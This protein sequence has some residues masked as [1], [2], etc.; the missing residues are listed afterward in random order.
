MRRLILLTIA[1]VLPLSGCNCHDEFES[2]WD[3]QSD[4]EFPEDA[5]V[6]VT[7]D[8]EPD[9]ADAWD[10]PP[11]LV[12]T[13]DVAD[14]PDA[15]PVEPWQPEVVESV[16]RTH[17]LTDRT[18]LAVDPDG[19][20]WLGYHEC[21][22]LGCD[23]PTLK[24]VHKPVGGEWAGERIRAHEGI[25]GVSVI[26]PQKPIVVFPDTLED[27]YKAAMRQ[28]DGSWRFHTFPVDRSRTP[29]YDGF[30]VT[31]DG[32]SYFVSF[33]P[34]DAQRVEF[35]AYDTTASRPQWRRKAPL[36]VTNPQAAMERGL[37]ADNGDSVY[38]VNQSG[39]SGVYGVYRYDE[40]V[41]AWPQSV[42]LEQLTSTFVH[43][44]F[45]TADYRLCMSGNY[46]DDLL[47]T[48]GSMFDLTGE[49]RLFRG[50]RLAYGHPSSIIE[51]TDGTLY[52]AFNPDG[53]DELRVARRDVVTGTWTVETVFDGPSYG[54]S[55]A[56]AQSGD[57]VISFYT[58]DDTDRC[59]LNVLW[60][61]PQ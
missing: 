1:A 19:T 58:C 8:V 37:R 9:I 38:L 16:S 60:E 30:D 48:C 44:L 33:A 47:V 41:D 22:T 27:T 51:G 53:N 54:V 31:N 43:S 57:L 23:N 40:E 5:G 36:E 10:A 29:R 56:I 46:Q 35:Y 11:D 13:V 17:A 32:K 45:I 18:S 50:E 55:T 42:E 59:S 20:L 49:T 7:A 26:E 61:T 12:D 24:V 28:P 3:L 6:D 2:G 15:P 4:L 34:Q 14:E 52:V 39:Q 25:F 21:N